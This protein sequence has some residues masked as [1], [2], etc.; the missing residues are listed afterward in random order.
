MFH[1]HKPKRKSPVVPVVLAPRPEAA[2]VRREQEPKKAYA[3]VDRLVEAA[4]QVEKT[5]P[6][7]DVCLNLIQTLYG[8]LRE[9]H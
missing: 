9:M 3:L 7:R 8:L 2:P 6:T 4:I 5:G 1:S